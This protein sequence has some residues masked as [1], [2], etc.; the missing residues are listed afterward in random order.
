MMQL[1]RLTD[2]KK[3]ADAE[4]SLN[5]MRAT[6]TCRMQEAEKKK[7]EMQVQREQE[8]KK[9]GRRQTER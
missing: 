5:P 9:Q 1:D 4:L 7:K 8:P 3:R 2:Q 6:I